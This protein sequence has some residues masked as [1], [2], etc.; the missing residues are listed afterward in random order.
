MSPTVPSSVPDS[1]P[2]AIRSVPQREGYG[3]GPTSVPIRSHLPPASTPFA[4]ADEAPDGPHPSH[5]EI[6]GAA[7]ACLW[8]SVLIRAAGRDRPLRVAGTA[9]AWSAFILASSPETR[10]AA[11]EG[12][13][14]WEA[15][16][17]A[18]K[19]PPGSSEGTLLRL[20]H[21]ERHG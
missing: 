8:P 19:T 6:L 21:S 3:N 5:A 18:T 4:F 15:S 1:S 20:S 11:W 2:K 16:S 17:D 9:A 13:E 14:E 10:L 7:R 12:L